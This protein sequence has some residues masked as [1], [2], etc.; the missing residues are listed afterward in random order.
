MCAWFQYGGRLIGSGA[1]HSSRL[2]RIL[3]FSAERPSM[4]KDRGKSSIGVQTS[5]SWIA[6]TVNIGD[7]LDWEVL[8][9]TSLKSYRDSSRGFLPIQQSSWRSQ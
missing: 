7:G 8:R 4:A 2:P 6:K 1:A 3:E 9:G 5:T